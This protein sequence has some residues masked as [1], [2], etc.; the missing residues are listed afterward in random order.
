MMEHDTSAVSVLCVDGDADRRHELVAAVTETAPETEATAAATAA[1]A[2]DRVADPAERPDCVLTA[3]ELPDTDGIGCLAAVRAVDSTVPVVV[4]TGDWSADAS[5]ALDAGATDVVERGGETAS[6]VAARRAV[7]AARNASRT[8]DTRLQPANARVEAL[9]ENTTDKIVETTLDGD[10]A[11]ITKANRSFAAM[12]GDEG[13][14][15]AL[16]GRDLDEVVLPVDRRDEGRAVNQ[17]VAEGERVEREVRRQTDGSVRDFLLRSVRVDGTDSAYFVYTDITERKRREQT[18]RLLH[19]AT[20]QMVRAETK[21]AVAAIAMH[22]VV[23]VLGLPKTT[24]YLCEDETLDPVV[25]TRLSHPEA[26]SLA[27]E[28]PLG[29]VFASGETTVCAS[30][31][32][33]ADESV[34]AV[35]LADHGVVTAGAVSTDSLDAATVQIAELLAANIESALDRAEREE[36]L[37]EREIERKKQ[38]DRFAALFENIPDPAVSYVF[39]ADGTM[40]VRAVN[41]A[42]EEVMGYDEATVVGHDLDEFIVPSDKEEEATGLSDELI[43]GNSVHVEVRRKTAMGLRDFILHGVP[44]TLGERSVFG[45]AIYTD[46]SEQ[47][48]RERKLRRQNE[49]LDEFASIVSHDLR[50]PLTVARGHRDLLAAEYDHESLSELDWALDRMEALIED[51]LTLARKGKA[52]EDPEPVPFER[53]VT[54]AWAG[55]ETPDSELVLAEEFPPISADGERLRAL[56]EN[57]FRNSVEHGT[58]GD[59]ADGDGGSGDENRREGGVTVTVQYHPAGFA[60]ADDGSGIDPADVDLVFEQGY[61]T[62]ATGTGFGLAIVEDI[63]EAHDWTVKVDDGADGARFVFSGVEWCAPDAVVECKDANRSGD[64]AVQ[65]R[66]DGEEDT[67]AGDGDRDE[68][69]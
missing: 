62:A 38:R 67:A 24:V 52:V 21:S 69:V 58:G 47:K 65:S 55:C 41:S 8:H 13:G 1:A 48:E 14:P 26:V 34:L 63:A 59:A 5:G 30:P 15:D 12:F 35:P 11:T 49:R 17:Q 68:S 64:P 28:T 46:T 39:D 54:S 16:V 2:R 61:T 4:V 36:L 25:T 10:T 3:A 32:G 29:D 37:R 57:L 19:D 6:R 33:D 43:A 53:I 18:M 60:V 56:F 7:A 42:F 9:F 40:Q 20:Q 22:T 27:E 50:N 51:V 44:V 45:F 23:N 66:T 31:A